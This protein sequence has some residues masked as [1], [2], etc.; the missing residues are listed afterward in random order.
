MVWIHIIRVKRQHRD[1]DKLIGKLNKA[2]SELASVRVKHGQS[3]ETFVPLM[4]TFEKELGPKE[5]ATF[6]GQPIDLIYFN[7]DEIV[8]A[9]VK[10]G[11]SKLSQKQKHIKNLVKAKKIRWIEVNDA[12]ASVSPDIARERWEAIM[13]TIPH[14]KQHEMSSPKPSGT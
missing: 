14:R 10:T 7:P 12:L 4:H 2:L 11:N 8:F 13:Q 5:N 1:H 3:W 6:L 9:E